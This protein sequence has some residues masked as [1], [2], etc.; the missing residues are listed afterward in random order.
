MPYLKLQTVKG[1]LSPEQK[2]TLMDGFTELLVKI[3]GGGNPDFRKH[4]WIRI[5]EGEPE[6][7]QIGELRPTAERVARMTAMRD[8]QDRGDR[9]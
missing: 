2:R 6:D 5:E 4:V 8:M 9:S 7:W 1:L 3:E